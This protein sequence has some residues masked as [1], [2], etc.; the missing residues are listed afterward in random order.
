MNNLSVSNNDY[1]VPAN[2]AQS[3]FIEKKSKFISRIWNVEDEETAIAKIKSTKK[4]FFD[5]KHNVYAYII[6]NGSVR[7]SDD[8]EPQ[9]TAGQPILE[10]LKREGLS[11]VCCVVTRYF[12][13]ILLGTG[14][15]AR[16]YTKGACDAVSLSGKSIVVQ[17]K[18]FLVT[19]GYENLQSVKHVLE[20]NNCIIGNIQYS[21]SVKLNFFVKPND[22]HNV[23]S[24]I[25][26]ITS[27]TAIIEDCGETYIKNPT[28]V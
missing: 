2:F 4:E 5:A 1:I 24:K 27:G 11:D 15:L 3:E 14:G 7:F 20:S 16:A 18:N 28:S 12:G 13:G 10:V 9:G 17:H 25:V 21:E 22:E 26:N 8:G 6:H 23:N 19:V